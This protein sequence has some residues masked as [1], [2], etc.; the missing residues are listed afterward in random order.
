M[1]ALLECFDL[2]EESVLHNVTI[3]NQLTIILTIASLLLA[4]VSDT[5]SLMNKVNF[6]IYWD[7]SQM[8]K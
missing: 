1:T 6:D 4:V 5:I 8:H 2:K 3:Y 7:K